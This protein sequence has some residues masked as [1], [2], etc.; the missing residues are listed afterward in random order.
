M[1]LV[2]VPGCPGT[3]DLRTVASYFARPPLRP[4]RAGDLTNR[5]VALEACRRH[6]DAAPRR[7]RV[8]CD[9]GHNT[10]NN[11]WGWAWPLL[12]AAHNFQRGERVGFFAGRPCGEKSRGGYRVTLQTD[13]TLDTRGTPSRVDLINDPRLSEADREAEDPAAE[14]SAA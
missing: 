7:R 9:D 1:F 14:G 10:L 8:P 11:F 2:H 5:P 13:H 4:M 3:S 6:G 12:A